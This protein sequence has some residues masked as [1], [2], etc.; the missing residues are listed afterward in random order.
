MKDVFYSRVLL[1]KH[2]LKVFSSEA[3]TLKLGMAAVFV[4]FF[5]DFFTKK[6]SIKFY[7][8]SVFLIRA[9]L[10]LCA[11]PVSF[12]CFE[13]STGKPGICRSHC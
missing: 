4:F 9:S 1:V 10:C 2:F 12:L 5:V 8:L 6:D 3:R 13:S 7:L 11:S